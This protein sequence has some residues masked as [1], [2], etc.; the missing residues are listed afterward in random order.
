MGKTHSIDKGWAI[1]EGERGQLMLFKLKKRH[2]RK[3]K[4]DALGRL[5]TAVHGKGQQT[6]ACTQDVASGF[7][8]PFH[9]NAAMP[10]YL[11]IVHHCCQPM[12]AELC[13]C[14]RDAAA[15]QSLKYLLSG[16]LQNKFGDP[17]CVEE[18]ERWQY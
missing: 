13:G 15:L 6:T 5:D 12:M 11:F 10:T 18:T 14:Y 7:A 9:C 3:S 4:S 17:W 2:S 16:P 8:I 1:S